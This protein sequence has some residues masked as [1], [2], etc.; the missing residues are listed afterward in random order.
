MQRDLRID[1]IKGLLILLVVFGHCHTALQ[2]HSN[3]M[4]IYNIIYLFHMPLFIFIS[5]YFTNLQKE[6]KTQIRSIFNI[7]LVYVIF[8]FIKFF[9][10]PG[11]SHSLNILRL[12]LTP[13][14]TMWYLLC[15][16][17]L[18][19][20]FLFCVK[21]CKLDVNKKL[22]ALVLIISLCMA[23]LPIGNQRVFTFAFPF[24]LG[25]YCKKYDC[26]K[27]IYHL[28]KYNVLI[29]A[30]LSLSV[31]VWVNNNNMGWL[32][33]GSK[34]YAKWPVSLWLCPAVRLFHIIGYCAISILFI[35]FCPTM[36]M[37][38]LLGKNTLFIYMY[39]SIVLVYLK[40][41]DSYFNNNVFTLFL[42]ISTICILFLL[43][44][45]PF[46]HYLI[47]PLDSIQNVISKK[48]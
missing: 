6:T 29:C 21:M 10:E 15:L 40:M 37:L 16:V 19:V 30:I 4:F 12:V 42:F 44:K 20:L 24:A 17:C 35:K 2:E 3:Y 5:G 46:L 38:N 18:R 26:L 9:I 41:F 48:K 27:Q 11:D 31:I 33:Y 28:N 32:L 14:W 36:N 39:H 34:F 43:F 45:I 1:S 8:Q 7:F 23:Y 25:L 13:K 47:N 22:I